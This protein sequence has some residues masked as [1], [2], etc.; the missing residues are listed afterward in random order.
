MTVL[1]VNQIAQSIFS[2]LV[3][4]MTVEQIMKN[5][6]SLNPSLMVNV[7]RS[8]ERRR[9]RKRSANRRKSPRRKVVEEVEEEMISKTKKSPKSRKSPTSKRSTRKR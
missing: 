6:Q 2:G 4:N 8:P 1:D 7:K 3:D 9:Q 5:I